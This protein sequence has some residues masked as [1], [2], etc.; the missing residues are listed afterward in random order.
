MQATVQDIAFAGFRA[1]VPVHRHSYVREPGIFTAA[2][3]E[4]LEQSTGIYERR[5]L[6]PHLCASDMCVAAATDLLKSL[7]WDPSTVEVLIFVSQDSDYNLPA[8]ACL[9]QNRLGLPTSCA[10]LDI[11]LGCSGFIYATWIASTMLAGASGKRA[12]V[13]CGD[14]STRHLMPEDRSTRPLF[15]DAGAA[16]ALEKRPGSGPMHVVM[17][18]D[19]RGAPHIVVRAGGRRNPLIPGEQPMTAEQHE[20]AYRDAR[21]SLNGPEV[22]SFSLRAVPPLVKANL[23]LAGLSSEQIDY[24]VLHQANKLMLDQIRRKIAVDAERFIVDLHDYGNTSSASIPLAI[25]SSLSD[26]LTSGR[27]KLMLAGFGVGWSWASLIAEVG[28]IPAP[29]VIEVPDDFPPLQL[30]GR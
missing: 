3:A 9:I 14:T 22:F 26:K 29:A 18:T 12:L 20:T 8:T 25:C 5:V 21:L 24:F 23:E 27:H 16:V 13:L 19:G 10:A 4:K 11:N 7:E 6:P 1:A 17:G 2:E 30:G 15:G 28:P